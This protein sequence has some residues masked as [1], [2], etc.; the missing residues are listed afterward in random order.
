MTVEP[1]GD[2]TGTVVSDPE[3]IDCGRTC[4]HAFD[5]RSTVTVEAVADEGSAFAG[6]GN[7]ACA[8]DETTCRLE[9]TA[10][11]RLAPNFDLEPVPELAVTLTQERGDYFGA[12][13]QSSVQ[14]TVDGK[15][16]TCVVAATAEQLSA[17][18]VSNTCRYEAPEGASLAV[19]NASNDAYRATCN[20]TETRLPCTFGMPAGGASVDLL[21]SAPV[22]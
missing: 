7:R 1:S 12:D 20:G 5:D 3:G 18:A 16:N 13:A 19:T 21:F 14:V 6:W 4:E 15:R 2:G 9:L 17:A 8:D 11:V 10:D 22:G